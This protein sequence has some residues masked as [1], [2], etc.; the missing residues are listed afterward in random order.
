MKITIITPVFPYPKPGIL[1]GIEKYVQNLVLGLKNLGLKVNIITSY[2]NGGSKFDRYKGIPITRILDS[3]KIL[4]KL[5]SILRLNHITLGFNLMLKK[6]YKIYY[7]SNVVIFTQPLGFTRYLKIKKIPVVSIAHHFSYVKLFQEYF[8]LPFFHYLQRRQFNLHKHIIA[9]SESTK[10]SLITH[11]HLNDQDIKV[12]SNAVDTEKFNSNKM[13][14]KIKEKY[15]IKTILYVGPM[16]YR[17]R[18][19]VLLKAMRIVLK[20][21]PD[22]HLILI[23]KGPLFNRLKKLSHSLGIHK[24]VTFLGFIKSNELLRYYASVVLFVLPSELEGFGQV[25]LEA[26]ASGTPVICANILPMSGII[27]N[28]GMTFILNDSKDLAKK[29][30]DLLENEEKRLRLR[31]NALELVKKYDCI[32]ISKEY[33]NYIKDLR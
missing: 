8:E 22:A 26:M 13:S 1:P 23:G 31:N 24:N 28:G 25:I 3:K 30:I 14:K 18:I 12:I 2:W 21:I 7:D 15:G 9:V 10:S 4:G 17:K 20:K 11:Y 29:I 19:P 16:I 32:Q 6:I 5:G 33:I 27:G